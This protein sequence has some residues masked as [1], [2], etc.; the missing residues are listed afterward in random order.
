MKNWFIEHNP[1]D[2]NTVQLR[3][4]STGLTAKDEV[5]CDQAIDIGLTLHRSLDNSHVSEAKIKRASQTRTIASCY[6][7]IKVS[8]N[9]IDVDPSKLF[10]RLLAMA[11]RED[12]LS[13]VF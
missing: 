4:L 7:N 8:G 3:S 1:F 9:V 11:Q 2:E 13:K 12:D 10:N 6:T 5:N